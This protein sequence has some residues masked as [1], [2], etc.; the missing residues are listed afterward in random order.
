MRYAL[1]SGGPTQN[2]LAEC[3]GVQREGRRPSPPL[4]PQ[5]GYRH[6]P[7]ACV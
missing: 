2:A 1:D 6:Y 7:S 3:G 5:M 4:L